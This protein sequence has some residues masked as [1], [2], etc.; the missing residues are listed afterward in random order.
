MRALIY[1]RKGQVELDHN[2][3][4]DDEA[5]NKMGAVT[6][7]CLSKADTETRETIT[8]QLEVENLRGVR[9]KFPRV[10]GIA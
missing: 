7:T 3:I 6:I 4:L 10:H 8:E 9:N 1:R 5:I 2:E